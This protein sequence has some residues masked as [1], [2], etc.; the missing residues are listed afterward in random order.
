[1]KC[2]SCFP[3]YLGHEEEGTGSSNRDSFTKKGLI[4]STQR[5]INFFRKKN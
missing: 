4:P 5:L 3:F 2:S 1:M